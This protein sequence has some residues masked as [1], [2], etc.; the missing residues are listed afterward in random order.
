MQCFSPVSIEHWVEFRDEQSKHI[1]K[2]Q[3]ND[4]II[5]ERYKEY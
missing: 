5:S 3:L 2:N 1:F 4:I